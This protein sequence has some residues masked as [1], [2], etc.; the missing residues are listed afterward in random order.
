M[1][2]KG[3]HAKRTANKQATFAQNVLEAY[4]V[5]TNKRYKELG[6]GHLI[7]ARGMNKD[8]VYHVRNHL[9]CT[10]NRPNHKKCQHTLLKSTFHKGTSKHRCQYRS[11]GEVSPKKY[12]FDQNGQ[13]LIFSY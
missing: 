5:Q 12:F 7:R 13:N 2:P 10:H 1:P 8:K 6:S 11:V 4:Q 9:L 3:V